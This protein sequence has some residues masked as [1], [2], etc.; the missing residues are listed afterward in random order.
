MS[1]K[2][3]LIVTAMPNPNEMESL[4]RYQEEAGKLF[5]QAGA[6]VKNKFE[7]QSQPIGS[8]MKKMVFVVEFD[9]TETINNLFDSEEYKALIPF[10][11]KGFV[12]LDAY[13]G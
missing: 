4:K 10:R 9:S 1:D 12:S 6:V 3:T 2:A 13:V 11:E 5:D 8:A 7:I